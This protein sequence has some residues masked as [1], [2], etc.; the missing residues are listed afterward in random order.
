M[1]DTKDQA[2]FSNIRD[3]LIS[4]IPPSFVNCNVLEV[5]CGNGSTLHKL[6]HLGIAKTTTGIEIFP[7]KKNHYDS[8]DHFIADD[9]EKMV[10]P[11]SLDGSFDLILLG[12]ILEHLIDPW[13]ALKKISDLLAPNGLL[14]VSIPNIRYYKVL[15]SIVWRGDFHYEEAGI[16][17]QTHLRFFCKKNIINLVKNCNLEVDLITSSFDKE[18]AGKRYWLNKILFN[19][20]HDFFVY[21][22]IIRAKKNIHVD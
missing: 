3:D 13:S 7:S 19:K 17:D 9:I 14:L 12:D 20:L 5:G 18:S 1:Y 2:Y 10:I 22:Y 21:Q 4:L 16:L 6:K 15:Q 11:T 8:L